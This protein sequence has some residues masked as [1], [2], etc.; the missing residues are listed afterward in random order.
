M[1]ATEPR[2]ITE[3]STSGKFTTAKI[4][5]TTD[6][7]IIK[8]VK[9]VLFPLF[10]IASFLGNLFIEGLKL[11]DFYCGVFLMGASVFV[12]TENYYQL[13]NYGNLAN[14]LRQLFSN[15]YIAI[16][17]A[18]AFFVFY[19]VE[20]FQS[21]GWYAWQAMQHRKKITGDTTFYPVI[22]AGLIAT[23]CEFVSMLYRFWWQGFDFISC[24][25]IF[26][27]LFGFKIGHAMFQHFQ[28]RKNTSNSP[29]EIIPEPPSPADIR[30]ED[31]VVI[32][33]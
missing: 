24:I 12:C 18:T 2:N 15:F 32:R 23:V 26:V 20:H 13:L 6:T 10:W 3:Q 19:V 11:A 9:V 8:L 5:K 25:S 17:V 16:S 33:G 22:L 31:Y 21:A 14:S 27:G 28:Q 7:F 4:Y 1:T 29:L 30:G